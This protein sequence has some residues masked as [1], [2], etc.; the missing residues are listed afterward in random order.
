MKTTHWI[1]FSVVLSLFCSGC[2]G[3]KR[4]SQ[5]P[6]LYP[7]V[8]VI[9][10]NGQPIDEVGFQLVSEN[11]SVPWGVGGRTNSSGEGVASTFQGT[12]SRA[13]C[14]EGK[15]KVVLNWT[16]LTGLELSEEEYVKLS[17][18]A[19]EA[20]TAKLEESR[21]NQPKIIPEAFNQSASDPVFIDIAK[22][23]RKIVLEL[24]QY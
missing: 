11:A 12:Y 7:L 23:T 2:G 17:A 14:P 4:P 1:F 16:P 3:E 6:T 10:N 21:R 19:V 9:Q 24:S 8:V 5:F 20:Y 22:E 18:E 13:G 15:F